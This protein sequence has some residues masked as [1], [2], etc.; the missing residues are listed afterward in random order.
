MAPLE[1]IILKIKQ[2]GIERIH[3]IL[4]LTMDPPSCWDN[5]VSSVILLKEL[6]AL[7]PT[8]EENDLSIVDGEFEKLLFIRFSFNSL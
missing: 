7:L 5:V 1:N 6:G 3:V 2:F 4:G 8:C